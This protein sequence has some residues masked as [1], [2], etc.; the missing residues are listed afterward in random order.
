MCFINETGYIAAS[1]LVISEILK[2]RVD[3]R[4]GFND[5]FKLSSGQAF[6]EDEEH[7][8]DADKINEKV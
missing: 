5:T 3:I 4:Y 1:L 7:F 8:I 6:D 2:V